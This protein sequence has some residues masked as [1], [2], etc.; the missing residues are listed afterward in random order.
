MFKY[1][2]PGNNKPRNEKKKLMNV[3][4]VKLKTTLNRFYIILVFYPTLI[5]IKITLSHETIS[6]KSYTYLF[7][8]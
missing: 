7:S 1:M 2:K 8:S 6:L 3:S 4:G 5:K